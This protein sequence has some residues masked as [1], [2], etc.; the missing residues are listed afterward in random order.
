MGQA[1]KHRI[2]AVV[3]AGCALCACGTTRQGRSVEPSGFL[4]DYSMLEE[5]GRGE[6][7]LRY[8]NPDANF[9]RYEKIYIESIAILAAEDSSLSR[10]EPE[11]AAEIASRLRDALAAELGQDYAIVDK[12]G[13]ATIRMRVALTEARGSKVV[14]DSVTALLPQ[15]RLATTAAQLAFDNSI[16]T[17]KARAECELLDATSG[18]RLMAAV[19]EQYGTK[20]LRGSLSRWSDVQDAFQLWARRLRLRLAEARGVVIEKS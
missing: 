14:I 7:Q 19:D 15:T 4:G 6:A 18:V 11:D 8:V 12:P 9:A 5:G 16:A 13:P 10:L 17:G 20:A 2:I 3:L 1:R